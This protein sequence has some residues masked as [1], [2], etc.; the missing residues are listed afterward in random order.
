MNYLNL[1]VTIKKRSRK[2]LRVV[3]KF[4]EPIASPVRRGDRLGVLV[5]NAPGDNKMELPLIAGASVAE[6]GRMGRLSALINHLL[7]GKS[8]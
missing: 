1:F 2:Q 5:V 6:L 4:T 3:A 7:W 8:Q